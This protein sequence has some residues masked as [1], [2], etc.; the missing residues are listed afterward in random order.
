MTA[1]ET[2]FR[3][4]FEE[5]D[6]GMMAISTEGCFVSVNKAF[7]RMLGYARSEL[8]SLSYLDIT[9]QDDR[10]EA[11]K[12]FCQLLSD[13]VADTGKSRRRYVHKTG[14]YVWGDSTK[15]LVRDSES[16]P[17]CFMAYVSEIGESERGLRRSKETIEALLNASTDRERN[18]LSA[19][20]ADTI[21]FSSK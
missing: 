16:R 19:F 20:V 7:C 11:W 10:N 21:S 3:V 12:S 8:E 9:H 2:I 5:A 17:L 13:G 15:A 4:A 1:D 18:P 14:H 6:L